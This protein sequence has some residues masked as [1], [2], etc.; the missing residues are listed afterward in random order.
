MLVQP[1]IKKLQ[2]YDSTSIDKE[3]FIKW[4][5]CVATSIVQKLKLLQVAS[6][7]LFLQWQWIGWSSISFGSCPWLFQHTLWAC[8][9]MFLLSSVS[10][11]HFVSMSCSYCHLWWCFYNIVNH[12]GLWSSCLTRNLT[13]MALFMTYIHTYK[14]TYIYIYTCMHAHVYHTYI[15]L[16]MCAYTHTYK[17]VRDAFAYKFIDID[18][19]MSL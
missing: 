15:R 4:Q 1:K 9:V 2:K 8:H 17:F 6:W 16:Y 5:R 3:A 10:M 14:H 12:D 18:T 11:S 19:C 13:Y 7:W